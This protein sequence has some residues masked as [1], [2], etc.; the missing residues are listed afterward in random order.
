MLLQLATVEKAG[1]SEN[2][3]RK[4][5]ESCQT[6]PTTKIYVIED[7]SGENEVVNCDSTEIY[8]KN[9]DMTQKN[10]C[11]DTSTE[12]KILND[13][14]SL[15]G[16]LNDSSSLN[17]SDS[18]NSA[19]EFE[20]V[21]NNELTSNCRSVALDNSEVDQLNTNENELSTPGKAKPSSTEKV[22]KYFGNFSS[23]FI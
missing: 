11:G 13:S 23:L 18:V 8:D 20:T 16:I 14:T 10:T 22:T 5:L 21:E 12:S 17:E 4:D 2:T 1:A 6:E 7:S 19:T 15:T 3:Q 9:I